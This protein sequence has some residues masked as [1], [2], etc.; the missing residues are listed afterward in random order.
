MIQREGVGP[1]PG[2]EHGTDNLILSFS[3]FLKMWNISWE[4]KGFQHL[5]KWL[6]DT[7]GSYSRGEIPP[8][9]SHPVSVNTFPAT[10]GACKETDTL[11]SQELMISTATRYPNVKLHASTLFNCKRIFRDMTFGCKHV[12]SN[13]EKSFL[14][15]YQPDRWHLHQT[16]TKRLSINPMRY[17]IY[18]FELYHCEAV[19]PHHRPPLHAIHPLPSKTKKFFFIS[20]KLGLVVFVTP[21]LGSTPYH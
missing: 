14:F 21:T 19:N 10:S 12:W 1:F 13:T 11:A 16:M 15:Q 6:G 18:T 2:F 5:Q 9:P 17:F 7:R 3:T 8:T 20:L 4:V